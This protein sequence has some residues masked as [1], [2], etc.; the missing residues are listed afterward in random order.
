LGLNEDGHTPLTLAAAS[1]SREMM[2][3]LVNETAVIKWQLLS[4][5]AYHFSLDGMELPVDVLYTDSAGGQIDHYIPSARPLQLQLRGALSYIMTLPGNRLDHMIGISEV[6]EILKKKWLR[7]GQPTVLRN[8]VVAF[9][10]TL[11]LSMLVGTASH[12]SKTSA[13]GTLSDAETYIL[14]VTALTMLIV[15]INEANEVIRFGTDYAGLRGGISGAAVVDKVFRLSIFFTF[16]V[17]LILRWWSWLFLEGHKNNAP[18]QLY[19][20]CISFA[21]LLSWFYSLM[22]AGITDYF[23]PFL[24]RCVIILRKD[25]LYF[26][27][28]YVLLILAFGI[29]LSLIAGAPDHIYTQPDGLLH[30]LI[31]IQ[32]L[33]QVTFRVDVNEKTYLDIAEVHSL[34]TVYF[35]AL[36]FVF[37]VLMNFLLFNLL[38]AMMSNTYD[39]EG[40]HAVVRMLTARYQL[41]ESIQRALSTEGA[42][43]MRDRYTL[44]LVISNY[45]DSNPRTSYGSRGEATRTH[46]RISQGRFPD[47]LGVHM[48]VSRSRADTTLTHR[49][50][51]RL[52]AL[53]SAAKLFVHRAMSVE[54]RILLGEERDN[55]YVKYFFEMKVSINDHLM[56]NDRLFPVPVRDCG[57]D[58]KHSDSDYDTG[59]CSTHREKDE[60]CD[61]SSRAA[62]RAFQSSFWISRD[63]THPRPGQGIRHGDV[64]M[65]IWVPIK[66]DDKNLA[67]YITQISEDAGTT[68]TVRAHEKKALFLICPQNDFHDMYPETDVP[69]ERIH[70]VQGTEC[71]DVGVHVT[72]RQNLGL[73]D[74][75]DGKII[76]K[77]THQGKALYTVLYDSKY[78]DAARYPAFRFKGALPIPGALE[79]SLRIS[80]LIRKRWYAFDEIFVVQDTHFKQHIS[81]KW[82]WK[83]GPNNTTPSADLVLGS[84]PADYT[85]IRHRDIVNK[86]WVPVNDSMYAYCVHYTYELE[87]RQRF[88][89][90]IW[91]DHCI[92]G[93]APSRDTGV[94][95]THP[96]H[97]DFD[98]NFMSTGCHI[99]GPVRDAISHWRRHWLIQERA[100]KEASVLHI[101]A[102]MYTEMYSALRA[103]VE[104][105]R[106]PMTS[107]NQSLLSA[108]HGTRNVY[109]CGQAL[110]HTVNYTI[111][112]LTEAWL[113]SAADITLLIDGASSVPGF[114]DVSSS[115]LSDM[116]ASGMQLKSCE[117]VIAETADFKHSYTQDSSI[118]TYSE[119]DTSSTSMTAPDNLLAADKPSDIMSSLHAV[120]RGGSAPCI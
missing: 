73:D 45:S 51:Y 16:V 70:A 61:L 94:T 88:T 3:A 50:S 20:A 8:F 78:L 103:E 18:L 109:I 89:H 84:Y 113:G 69:I 86:V 44:A 53:A 98:D 68:F 112:D 26:G 38:I 102:N 25:V 104:D 114:E 9:V 67:L 30:A 55:C 93:A 75:L 80:E 66:P 11:Q 59:K 106:D 118:S 43:R 48:R 116:R 40:S 100:R 33:I 22:Y 117:E 27:Q 107:M 58:I 49:T 19:H 29:T 52:D 24:I 72:V 31:L 17:A 111:R 60:R 34:L 65:G 71:I 41:M 82:F 62:M 74:W 13:T 87:R 96:N 28:L 99:I 23:G 77:H 115:L 12:I 32:N 56:R 79:D 42:V 36:L 47:T 46:T 64:L 57:G 21:C 1:A 110:S 91:P 95:L 37:V 92:V 120:I 63:R 2:Q 105:A 4:E 5:I 85:E 90:K 76:S 119:M 101:G 108:L 10:V 35:E 54:D 39:D 81:H 7:F 97:I 14:A 6:R 15:C 83:R